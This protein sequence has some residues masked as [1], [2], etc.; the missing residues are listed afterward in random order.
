MP[1]VITRGKTFGATEEVT[2]AKLH[3]M[4]D[5]AT[6]ASIDQTNLAANTGIVEIGSSQPSDNDALW[7]D[8]SGART[9]KFHDGSSYTSVRGVVPPLDFRSGLVIT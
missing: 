1:A 5:S 9:L 3:T 6:I 2:N 8:T 7:V 4:V